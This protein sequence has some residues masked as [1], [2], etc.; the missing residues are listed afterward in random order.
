MV[1]ISNH[2]FQHIL[3]FFQ[4]SYLIP[5]TRF[6]H[7]VNKV[8]ADWGNTADRFM[9]WVHSRNVTACEFHSEIP[10]N[11]T[12]GRGDG[13]HCQGNRRRM[14]STSEVSWVIRGSTRGKE[15]KAS[16]EGTRFITITAVSVSETTHDTHASLPIASSHFTNRT[17][18]AA[19]APSLL[20][21]VAAT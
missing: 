6:R 7:L 20:F 18:P 12:T 9:N 11:F 8:F 15:I 4:Y 19:Q 13:R 10:V 14:Q 5:P 2:I 16:I 1:Y 3:C 17:G 21:T